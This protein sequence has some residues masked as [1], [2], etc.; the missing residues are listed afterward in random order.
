MVTSYMDLLQKTY[1][2]RLDRD[3]DEYIAF[4]VDGAH[5]MQ[6]L[7]SDLLTYSRITSRGK[8]PQPVSMQEVFDQTVANLRNVIAE[9][10]AEITHDSLPEVIG[11]ETQFGQLLMNLFSNAMKF[12]SEQAPRIHLGVRQEGARWVFSVRDNGIGID[13]GSFERI[14]QVFQ[15]LHTRQKCPGSG[16]GLAICKRIVERHGG[17]IWLESQVGQGST[18]YFTVPT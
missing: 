18:F 9:T 8:K 4:A 14:F 3:A 6:Q 10:G 16:I 11:D 1:K 13:S 15:R 7:I 12:R 2:D 17:S 5:R